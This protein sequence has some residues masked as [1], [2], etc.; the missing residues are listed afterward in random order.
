MQ[1]D[2]DSLSLTWLWVC[3][4]LTLVVAVWAAAGAD[5]QALR[6]DPSALHRF[7]ACIVALLVLWSIRATVAEGPGLHILGVTTVTLLLGP[8]MALMATLVAE[9]A[10]S[11][12]SSS[13]NAI[14]ASWLAG[15]VLP[16]LATD[17]CRRLVLRCLPR[18]P[19]SFIF[20]CGFFGAALAAAAAYLGAF[21]MIGAPDQIWS[22]AV[23]SSA[24]FFLLVAFPEAFINGCL[25]TLLVVYCP[26]RIAGY[27]AEYERRHRL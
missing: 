3:R 18:D 6:R 7:A 26:G 2:A 22:G 16:V 9:I 5:W 24:A 15:A 23:P 8:A 10:T 21:L 11:L 25:I 20:G 14:A 12:G 17:V 4:L 19:F 1:I 27:S 13:D